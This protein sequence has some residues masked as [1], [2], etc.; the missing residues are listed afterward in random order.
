MPPSPNG[1]ERIRVVEE[2]KHLIADQ[3]ISLD[4]VRRRLTID[5]LRVLR[6]KASPGLD[7]PLAT[8]QRLAGLLE[9]VGGRRVLVPSTTEV[10][11]D[12]APVVVG[13]HGTVAHEVSRIRMLL[14]EFEAADAIALRNM[15]EVAQD[16]EFEISRVDTVEDAPARLAAGDVDIALLDLTHDHSSGVVTLARAE[17]A[18]S[19]VPIIAVIARADEPQL[20]HL[21]SRDYLVKS[22]INS[23][24]LVRTLRNAV[25]HD[26]LME[27]LRL[28]RQRE[29]FHATRDS[30]TGLP[31]RHHFIEQLERAIALAGRRN[32]Q[33]AVCFLDLDR[34]KN[35]NDTLGHDV[36]DSLI[37]TM[38]DRLAGIS[39]ASDM[40]ARVGG[41]EFLMLLQGDDL[42]HAAAV[43]AEKI[44]AA[45]A[46]P[47]RVDG[48][49]YS[50]SGSV[51][52]SLHP[53]D[54]HDAEELIRKAD[55]AMY[56]AKASGRARFQ[57]YNR[58]LSAATERKLAVE[59]R[60]REAL[61]AGHLAV[62]YQP[63][64]D[65]VR[66]RII[67]CEALARWN[68]PVLGAVSPLEFVPIAEESGIIGGVGEWV[69]E[70]ACAQ[71]RAWADAGFDPLRLSVN[72]SARQLFDESVRDVFVGALFR[73]GLEPSRL[74]VE[75]GEQVLIDN[76]DLAVEVLRELS[77][78]GIGITVDD[79]GTGL[80]SLALLQRYP[81]DT[82]KIDRAFVRDLLNAPDQA[83]MTEAIIA[84]ADKLRLR[85]VAEGVETRE[86]LEF[87]RH[88]GCTEM[89][90]FLFSMALAP[91]D[92]RA[93]LTQ[94]MPIRT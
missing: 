7:V 76:R 34:F 32:G 1:Q 11:S 86:Q 25:E 31:N 84:V 93:L 39:R 13:A 29:Q 74:E 19:N 80:S 85:V 72:V 62:H 90:G 50:F 73:T 4:E 88:R 60:L 22:Q 54:G 26:R 35:I 33:V 38:A 69:L 43:V 77:E 79:F 48:R 71:H 66:G 78:I 3:R 10:S 42:E 21:G 5:D 89:Q 57:L 28:A 47:F 87:L 91:D 63:R 41:D 24:L 81:I 36:G 9:L 61:E 46:R 15:L 16:T 59:A 75:I 6:R 49:E 20:L 94:G 17:V 30:M 14:I 82:V 68:D 58:A 67:G 52:V 2:V 37:I 83:A 12:E 55:A 51:G 18:A 56:Q 27:E 40:V 45:L 44:L 23:R 92:F 53:R 64:I 70:T 8:H 65:V